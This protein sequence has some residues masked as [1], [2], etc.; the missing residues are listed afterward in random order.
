MTGKGDAD[1]VFKALA[2]PT[3]RA[4]LDELRSGPKTTGQICTAN[5]ELD[6]CTVMQH[7][8]VLEHADL[9]IRQRRG[10]E[11]WNHLN[12]VP[13]KEIYERWISHYA[14]TAV[15]QLNKLKEELERS[16]SQ[17]GVGPPAR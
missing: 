17:Q 12:A 1:T 6:R 14:E 11:R 8:R 4:I 5:A 2:N 15:I 13:I 16:P 3:R 9:V 7:L 10:R